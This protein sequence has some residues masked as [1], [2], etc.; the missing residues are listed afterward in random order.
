MCEF[1]FAAAVSLTTYL[2]MTAQSRFLA[3]GGVFGGKIKA[4]AGMPIFGRDTIRVSS[5]KQ[6]VFP[7]PLAIETTLS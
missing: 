7:T 4:Q 5:K 2:A 3:C 1:C 6:R